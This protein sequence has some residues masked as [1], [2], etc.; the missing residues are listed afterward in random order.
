MELQLLPELDFCSHGEND[1]FEHLSILK[2]LVS[3]NWIQTT[4]VRGFVW[5]FHLWLPS[6]GA[7]TAKGWPRLLSSEVLSI[8][9]EL[10]LWL[11][12]GD[13]LP[14]TSCNSLIPES[15]LCCFWLLLAD[16]EIYVNL[17]FF[18]LWLPKILVF[19]IFIGNYDQLQP[20]FPPMGIGFHSSRKSEM[21]CRLL[22]LRL[23]L[24]Y[25]FYGQQEW[26]RS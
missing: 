17:I 21:I 25:N 7:G 10:C 23:C 19:V 22:N 20:F 12:T 1:H 5:H 16:E 3:L 9:S 15:Q 13:G 8:N 4:V 2:G 18:S 24:T 26:I 6:Q 14:L 11:L